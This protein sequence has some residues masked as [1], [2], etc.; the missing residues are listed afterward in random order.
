[1]P[2]VLQAAS[3]AIAREADKVSH[4]RKLYLSYNLPF[5]WEVV[6]EIKSN[7]TQSGLASLS[8]R[9]LASEDSSRPFA[10]ILADRNGLAQIVK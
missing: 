7:I 4:L 9:V 10:Y 6:R 1:M 3:F 2:S 8:V 5:F